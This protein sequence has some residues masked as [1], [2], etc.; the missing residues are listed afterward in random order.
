MMMKTSDNL[1][2]KAVILVLLTQNKLS[3]IRKELTATRKLVLSV[4][5]VNSS[6]SFSQQNVCHES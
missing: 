6:T 4:A 1:T 5:D 3:I 2:G